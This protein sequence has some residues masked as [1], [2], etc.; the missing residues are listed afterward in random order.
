M[1]LYDESFFYTQP[2][3]GYLQYTPDPQGNKQGRARADPMLLLL[4][5]IRGPLMGPIYNFLLPPNRP[6]LQLPQSKVP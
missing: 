1:I 6:Y 3:P 2:Y 5:P 4:T